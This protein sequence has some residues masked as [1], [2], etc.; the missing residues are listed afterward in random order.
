MPWNKRE[1]VRHPSF[2][3]PEGTR[4]F[5]CWRLPW[6]TLCRLAFT[7]RILSRSLSLPPSLSDCESAGPFGKQGESDCWICI[8]LN[9]SY[10]IS[11]ISRAPLFGSSFLLLPFLPSPAPPLHHSRTLPRINPWSWGTTESENGLLKI[12]VFCARNLER[13]KKKKAI[14]PWWRPGCQLHGWL[15]R[16]DNDACPCPPP[17]TR[18]ATT[19]YGKR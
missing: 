6:C 3:D 12:L 13:K 14:G 8:F 17:R 10:C 19:L 2:P 7:V 18:M 11:A 5:G 9:K 15:I 16:P 1:I 4:W